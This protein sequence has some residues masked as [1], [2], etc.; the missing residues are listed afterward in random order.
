M[1]P[2]VHVVVILRYRDPGPLSVRS[3]SAVTVTASLP[4]PGE[5]ILSPFDALR[6]YY[7]PPIH[8]H[9]LSPAVS[10]SKAVLSLAHF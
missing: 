4:S 3:D 8:Q 2:C 9:S 6:N 1:L 7:T 10:S 5:S